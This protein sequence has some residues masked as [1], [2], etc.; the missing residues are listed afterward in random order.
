MSQS[1]DA[2]AWEE[3]F[4]A[5]EAFQTPCPYMPGTPE[6]SDWLDGWLEG[7]ARTLGLRYGRAARAVPA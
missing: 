5:G 3:G 1:E 7:S 2:N 4:E 6:E